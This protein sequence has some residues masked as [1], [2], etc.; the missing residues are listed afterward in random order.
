MERSVAENVSY[1]DGI[2]RVTVVNGLV[3]IDLVAAVPPAQ[4][5]GQTQILVTHRLVMG[6]AQFVR[7][8]SETSGH[9]QRMEGLGLIKR[10]P[11]SDAH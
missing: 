3:H 11:V 6:L 10:E 9:L 7:L 4:D 8:C 1:V 5:A 2:G